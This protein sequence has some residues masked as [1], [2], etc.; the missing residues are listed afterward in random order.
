[1]STSR[2]N[3]PGADPT[4]VG[5]AQ[6]TAAARPSA[7]SASKGT[8]QLATDAQAATSE[9]RRS[10]EG[11]T[12]KAKAKAEE[13]KRHAGDMAEDTKAQVRSVASQQKDAAAERVAG[14]AQALRTAADDLRHHD[15]PFSAGYMR[16]AA[17]GL[18]RVS[19]TLRSQDVDDVMES[20]ENFARRQPVAFL[21][22]AVLTGFALARFMKSSAE[23]R[24]PSTGYASDYGPTLGESA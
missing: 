23:R 3:P 16:Q 22:G 15:Q 11:L 8:S 21:G 13:L 9:A 24:R 5:P 1:M 2:P 12:D 18:E 7:P 6:P 17:D 14:F 20:V 4:R 10:A 19:G